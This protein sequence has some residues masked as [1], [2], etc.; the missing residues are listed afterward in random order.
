VS[1]RGSET[2]LNAKVKGNSLKGW[3]DCIEYSFFKMR[4]DIKISEDCERFRG[5]AVGPP[6]LG[7]M[8]LKGK[9]QE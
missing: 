1:T 3:Y 2:K 6:S 7:T 4:I 5:K 8:F 9:R